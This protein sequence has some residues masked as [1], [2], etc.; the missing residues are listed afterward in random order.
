MTSPVV[1]ER[2]YHTERDGEVRPLLV[3]WRQPVPDPRGD[4]SCEYEIEWPDHALRIAKAYGVDS[5][6]ALYLALQT[7]ASEL[8]TAKPAVFF[9]EPDDILHLPVAG[10]EDL[11]AARTKGRS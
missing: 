1:C 9:F 2:T 5:V 11:E 8:Y 7:V 6:Q 10:V 4:W 3:R